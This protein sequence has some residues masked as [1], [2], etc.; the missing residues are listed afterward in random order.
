MSNRVKWLCCRVPVLALLGLALVGCENPP[1]NIEVEFRLPVEVED[2]ITENVERVVTATGTLRPMQMA[3][4]NNEV[5]GF[6]YVARKS[7]G[8]RLAEGDSVEV[9][10]TIAEITGEDARLHAGIESSRI[11]LDNVQAELDRRKNLFEQGVIAEADV[12]QQEVNLENALLDYERSKLNAAKSKLISPIA[13]VI[14]KLARNENQ[15]PLADGQLVAPGFRVADIAPLER[16]VADVDLVGPELSRVEVDMPV[17]VRHFAYDE[18]NLGTV[19]RLAPTLNA[20]TH[21]FR[22]EITVDNSNGNFRP[23][24]FVETSIITAARADVNV[25]PRTAVTRR[26]DTDVVFVVNGQRVERRVVRL[27]LSN[28]EYFEI[29]DGVSTGDQVVVRGLETLTDGARI[30][31]IGA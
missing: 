2:V 30:R 16:L 3:Y 6:I 19:Q 25:V 8:S 22:V 24:M 29:V 21:T 14:L 13:G 9:G 10:Q 7:D 26:S 28:D 23:G 4:L 31:V 20:T 11:A 27:G 18:P 5:P 12:R 17:R 1:P 15:Q